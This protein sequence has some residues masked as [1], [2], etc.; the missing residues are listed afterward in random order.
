ME[1]STIDSFYEHSL[2][3][4]KTGLFAVIEKKNYFWNES[5][6]MLNE[7]PDGEPNL[8][9]KAV[10]ATYE[11]AHCL[12]ASRMD[13]IG[14]GVFMGD[15]SKQGDI[16]LFPISE[17]ESLDIDHE[18]QFKYLDFIYRAVHL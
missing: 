15:F 10:E 13:T 9:T 1:T 12:Y 18:W 2:Q 3:T 8:N 11:A 16:E 17:R 4:P 7:W 6:K 5:G 14:D